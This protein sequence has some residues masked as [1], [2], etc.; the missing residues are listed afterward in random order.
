M[1]L[2]VNLNGGRLAGAMVHRGKGGLE[3]QHHRVE[4]DAVR[5]GNYWVASIFFLRLD[6]E[7]LTLTY[8][9]LTH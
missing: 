1:K 2:K 7:T 8:P 4:D 9:P 5:R 6:S 3:E